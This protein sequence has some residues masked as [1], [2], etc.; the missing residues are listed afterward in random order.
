MELNVKLIWINSGDDNMKK[1]NTKILLKSK[2]K[3]QK[4]CN[5]LLIYIY[6]AKVR[7]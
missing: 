5:N 4:N 2:I 6:H 7:L 1:K 3:N